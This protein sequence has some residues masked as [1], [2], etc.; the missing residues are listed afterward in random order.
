MSPTQL[1]TRHPRRELIAR[2][3]AVL[4]AAWAA[5]EELAGPKRLTDEAAFLPPALAL[6]ETPVHPAPRRAMWA[7]FALVVATLL[8][9]YF[10]KLDIVVVAPGR[11]VVSDGTKVIQPLEAGIVKAIHVRDGMRVKA[12]QVLIELDPTS[13][14]ADSQS[15]NAQVAATRAEA[16]R[17]VAL[18]QALGTMATERDAALPALPSGSDLQTQAEWADIRS[19]LERFDAE[20]ARREAEGLTARTALAKL[21]NTAPLVAQ[22]EA[23]VAALVKQG[24]IAN[25]AGQDRARE[26]IEIEQDLQTQNARVAEARAALSESMRSQASYLAELRR[27]LVERASKAKFELGQLEPQAAKAGR[28]E[29]VMQLKA[30]VSGTVQQLAVRT[31]DGVVTPAQALLVVVPNTAE[32]TAEVL[33]ENKD[34]GYVRDGQLADVKVDTFD[35]TRYGTV[36]AVIVRLSEDAV[37]DDKQGARFVA[38][39]RFNQGQPF[40]RRGMQ[41]RLGSGMN[42]TAEIRAGQQSILDYFLSPLM[43]KMSSSLSER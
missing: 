2:Y 41:V 26:R 36:D 10:G 23:D 17:A 13:A 27:V 32:L 15:V 11:I 6:Q 35:F 1:A 37:V 7:I 18:L 40:K 22:R 19:R 8:W 31:L 30:P 24:F 4:A 12:G 29:Q 25:H 5:R 21:Q 9:A 20:I 38:S 39:L 14:A 3:R 43:G 33:I 28:R 34:I 16:A 42:I